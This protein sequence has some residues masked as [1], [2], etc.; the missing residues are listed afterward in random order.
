MIGGGEARCRLGIYRYIRVL[1]LVL[2]DAHHLVS[3]SGITGDIILAQGQEC[4]RTGSI[5]HE[6]HD[7]VMEGKYR[8]PGI[9]LLNWKTELEVYLW[10]HVNAV[11]KYNNIQ[12]MKNRCINELPTS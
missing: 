9:N 2:H 6:G 12:I 4:E 5:F 11:L 8:G 10:R 7:D 1:G 3:C